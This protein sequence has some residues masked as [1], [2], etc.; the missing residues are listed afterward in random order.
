MPEPKSGAFTNSA[1]GAII[2]E[3]TIANTF[4]D[5]GGAG[6]IRTYSVSYVGDLQ[7][8]AFNQFGTRLQINLRCAMRPIYYKLRN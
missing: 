1:K 6:R 7:S 3:T 4:E 2:F 8:L 5:N